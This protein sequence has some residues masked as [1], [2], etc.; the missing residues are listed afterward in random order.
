MTE[1][2]VSHL[3]EL[4]E[5]SL[6]DARSEAV[7]QFQAS[8]FPLA[9]EISQTIVWPSPAGNGWEATQE[10]VQVSG[11]YF[12]MYTI[13]LRAASFSS[14]P[15]SGYLGLFRK[16]LKELAEYLS[17]KTDLGSR[18]AFGRPNLQGA[19]AIIFR[20]LSPLAYRY[21]RSLHDLGTG[22]PDVIKKCVAEL[23]E[24]IAQ[25]EN[26]FIYQLAL[27]GIAPS[28]EYN[29]RGV[30]LR[31][32]S[33]S[34]RG[35][36]LRSNSFGQPLQ[37]VPYSDLITPQSI[38]LTLPSALLTITA[39]GPRPPIRDAPSATLPNQVTLA[40]FLSGYDISG[41]GAMVRCERPVWASNGSSSIPF[42]VAEKLGSGDKPIS[43]EQFIAVVNLAYRIPAFSGTEGSGKEIVFSRILRGCGVHWRESGFLDFAIALE[44][45]LLGGIQNELA[46]RF[47]LYGALFLR[48][49]FDASETFSQLKNIYEVRSKLVHGGTISDS[50]R[51]NA[52]N[53]APRLATAVVLKAIETGWPEQRTLDAAALEI[54]MPGDDH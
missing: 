23:D 45:A 20:Y 12:D 16:Q 50:D 9:S 33:P 32:L 2:E 1:D 28:E 53:N 4:V 26:Y 44:A 17:E 10:Q 14:D 47:R 48:E 8:N 24:L 34:E 18:P 49:Q 31:P 3:Y 36:Y 37:S 38:T 29:H 5:Q 42:P 7:R 52:N 35:V 46:Y 19:E 27:G 54:R 43:L 39:K 21:L 30:K 51:S 13:P 6:E 41:S 40:L 15:Q 25:D 22:E 11:F